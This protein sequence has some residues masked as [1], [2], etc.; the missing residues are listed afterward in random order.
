MSATDLPPPAPMTQPIDA[1]EIPHPPSAWPK[2]IGVITVIFGSLAILGGCSGAVSS[3]FMSSLSGLM[4]EEQATMYDAMEGLKP[5]LI[6]GAVLTLALGI[7]LL[8]AGIGLVRRRAWSPTACMVWAGIKM[9]FVV[10][11]TILSD[12]ARQAQFEAMQEMMQQDPNMPA[13]AT[14]MMGSFFQVFGVFAIVLGILWGWALPIFLLSW[15]SRSKVKAEV[16]GW[17][18]PPDLQSEL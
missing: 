15:F 3:L 16:A 18:H 11:Y 8:V 5:W 10:G 2:V 7:L 4:P 9:V 13:G 1:G 6:I 12:M 17:Q 14:A